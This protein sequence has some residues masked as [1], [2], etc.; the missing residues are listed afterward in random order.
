MKIA[1]GTDGEGDRALNEANREG[2]GVH[3]TKAEASLTA[4]DRVQMEGRSVR[5]VSVLTADLWGLE[6]T[7]LEVLVGA[8]GWDRAKGTVQDRA[9]MA[10][11]HEGLAVGMRRGF[12]TVPAPRSLPDGVELA[13]AVGFCVGPELSLSGYL[14]WGTVS[15]SGEL[16]PVRGA[17]PVAELAA[18]EG[19]VLVVP[20]SL[21]AEARLAGGRVLA[22]STLKE[23]VRWVSSHTSETTAAALGEGTCTF[24]GGDAR[25]FVSLDL[26]DVRGNEKAVRALEVA[27]AGR[28]SLLLRGVPGAG[29][30]ML[31]RRLVDLLPPMTGEEVLDVVRIRSVAGLLDPKRSVTRQRPFRAPHHTISTTGLLGGFAPA[32]PGEVSLATHGVLFLDELPEFRGETIDALRVAIAEGKHRVV[33]L[34]RSASFPARPLLVAATNPCPCGYLGSSRECRCVS[35]AIDSHR[36]RVKRLSFELDVEVH[37]MTH[38]ELASAPMAATTAAVAARVVKAAETRREAC[39]EARARSARGLLPLLPAELRIARGEAEERGR[40]AV[41]GVARTIAC[42]AGDVVLRDAHMEEALELAAWG[43]P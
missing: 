37:R 40:V 8:A 4:A 38:E 43:R 13:V 33:R 28:H 26:A 30:T 2:G 31:A 34:G 5:L 39:I 24:G 16:R 23:L 3:F 36:A 32:R 18:R 14:F 22:A 35:R 29:K 21:E 1:I 41:A 27:A 15:L 19:K 20:S 7:L 25:P 42:L 6:A 9:W 11:K 12:S 10:A 17:F